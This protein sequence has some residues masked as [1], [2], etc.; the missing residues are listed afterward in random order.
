MMGRV[1]NLKVH[2]GQGSV[3]TGHLT[4]GKSLPLSWLLLPKLPNETLF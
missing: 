2:S 1:I 4:L 3:P